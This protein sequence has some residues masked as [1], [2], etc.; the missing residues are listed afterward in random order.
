M[1]RLAAA[2]ALLLVMVPSAALAAQPLVA[3]TN[4]DR[5][6]LAPLTQDAT[7]DRFAQARADDML[8][9]NY[10]SH[11]TPEGKHVWDMLS[12]DGYCWVNVGENA[13][14][15]F[16]PMSAADIEAAF[17]ASP[18]H[19]RNIL[20]PYSKIGVGI[21]HGA[22]NEVVVDVIFTQPCIQDIGSGLTALPTLPPTSTSELPGSADVSVWL[23]VFWII[24][25]AVYIIHDIKEK[26]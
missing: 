3:L 1:K 16:R 26:R 12:S 14:M 20:G 4:A 25:V 7:L 11:V 9:R 18:E 13:L 8:T 23:L 19:R 17:M 21:A 15:Q 24:L 5:A 22:D 10:L 6:G 2:L